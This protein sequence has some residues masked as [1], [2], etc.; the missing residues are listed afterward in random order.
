VKITGNNILKSVLSGTAVTV[1]LSAVLL[2]TGC[3]AEETAEV[4]SKAPDFELYDLEGNIHKLNDYKGSPV[5]L[6]FWATWCGPCRSEMPHLEDIYN[7]WK[8]ND[9]VFFAVNVGESSSGVKAFLDEY[10]F[11]MPVLMDGAKTVMSRYGISGIPTTYFIDKDGIIQDRVV[12]AFR[13]KETIEDY[14]VEL[15]R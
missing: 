13:D 10:G 12:G 7:E 6:N 2:F 5:L 15:Y 8:Y 1:L 14:L 3:S 4:G 11:A 9:L